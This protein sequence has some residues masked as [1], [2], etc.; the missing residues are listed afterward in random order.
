MPARVNGE[1]TVLAPPRNCLLIVSQICPMEFPLEIDVT[2]AAQLSKLP[3]NFLLDVRE[4]HEIEICR[5]AGSMNIPMGEISDRLANLPRDQRILVLCHH[6]GRSMRV[7]QFLR[8][9][10]YPQAS[11]ISGGIDAWAEAID[12]GMARY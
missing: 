7:T 8:T 2:E 5:I 12:P 6:G 9:N 4:P 3:G 11:N 1:L 10:N